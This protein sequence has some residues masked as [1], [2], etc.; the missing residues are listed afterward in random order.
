MFSPTKE[1]QVW[2]FK[3]KDENLF[4]WTKT[5]SR[6]KSRFHDLRTFFKVVWTTIISNLIEAHQ[7]F[8]KCTFLFIISFLKHK[9][10]SFFGPWTLQIFEHLDI[11]ECVTSRLINSKQIKLCLW[12][13]SSFLNLSNGM[14]VIKNA[15][16]LTAASDLALYG[17]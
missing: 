8:S 15:Y 2:V 13:I 12:P 9:L 14:Q 16:N 4:F 7:D 10:G 3:L 17:S 5:V 1:F 6:W 11:C